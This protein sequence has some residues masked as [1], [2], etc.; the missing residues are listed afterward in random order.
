[1]N[2]TTGRGGKK[3]KNAK[4]KHEE[5]EKNSSRRSSCLPPLHH[6]EKKETEK[7]GNVEAHPSLPRENHS[8]E[9]FVNRDVINV[10][11]TDGA[12]KDADDEGRGEGHPYHY[13]PRENMKKK[14][15]DNEHEQ[16]SMG[17]LTSKVEPAPPSPT[18]TTTITTTSTILTTSPSFPPEGSSAYEEKR[19][20]QEKRKT[21]KNICKE[22]ESLQGQHP[23]QQLHQKEEEDAEGIGSGNPLHFLSPSPPPTTISKTKQ[24]N[25]YGGSSLLVRPGG[26]PP[27]ASAPAPPRFPFSSFSSSPPPPSPRDGEEGGG[28]P[29]SLFHRIISTSEKQESQKSN[30]KNKNTKEKKEKKGSRVHALV[31]QEEVEEERL[32]GGGGPEEKKE[33]KKKGKSKKE[34]E[35]HLDEKGSGGR[36]RGNRGTRRERVPRLGHTQRFSYLSPT[37]S[38]ITSSH[39]M[40]ANFSISG[41]GSGGGGP[42]PPLSVTRS[43]S[44][45]SS[46]S[47]A[48]SFSPPP[49]PPFF[50]KTSPSPRRLPPTT[51]KTTTRMEEDEEEKKKEKKKREEGEQ[52]EGVRRVVP[53]SEVCQDIAHALESLSESLFFY[54][55]L[56]VKK[57]NIE[58]VLRKV[59]TFLLYT[60]YD[61]GVS[62]H[63]IRVLV[64]VTKTVSRGTDILASGMGGGMAILIHFLENIDGLIQQPLVLQEVMQWC[65]LMTPRLPC[66]SF[67]LPP[68]VCAALLD[69]EWH[70]VVPPPPAAPPSSLLCSSSSSSV[71]GG[72]GLGVSPTITPPPTTTGLPP[73]PFSS[74]PSSSFLAF[75]QT[76]P[77][78]SLYP[79]LPFPLPTSMFLS[80][81]SPTTTTTSSQEGD[82]T[83]WPNNGA[84]GVLHATEKKST[85]MC[86]IHR[87]KSTFTH[88]TSSDDENRSNC[89]TG[90]GHITPRKKNNG[91]KHKKKKKM[92]NNLWKIIFGGSGGG[93]GKDS[94]KKKE[95]DHDNEEDSSCST[96]RDRD[97]DEDEETKEEE[98][99]GEGNEDD[100]LNR[101]FSS[102]P[103]SSC[104]PS[105]CLASVLFSSFDEPFDL[106]LWRY[107]SSLAPLPLPPPPITPTTT[108]TTMA[109]S[110]STL[111]ISPSPPSSS[112]VQPS[113]P[114]YSKIITESKQFQDEV[115]R[116]LTGR[117][118]APFV[119]AESNIESSPPAPLSALSS[120]FSSSPPPPS[121]SFS[122]GLLFPPHQKKTKEEKEKETALCGILSWM[123]IR[124]RFAHQLTSFVTHE[125]VLGFLCSF[126]S[127]PLSSSS[128]FDH[129][130]HRIMV[131]AMLDGLTALEGVLQGASFEEVTR[132]YRLYWRGTFLRGLERLMNYFL[133]ASKS[134]T[135]AA[136]LVEQREKKNREKKVKEDEMEEKEE[137]PVVSSS[138]LSYIEWKSVVVPIFYRYLSCLACYIDRMPAEQFEEES[139][140]CPLQRQ[141]RRR[142]GS[143][144]E[145]PHPPP[146]QAGRKEE[147]QEKKK[148]GGVVVKLEGEGEEKKNA[149]DHPSLDCTRRGRE[150]SIPLRLSSPSSL[151]CGPSPH[152]PSSHRGKADGET[153]VDGCRRGWQQPQQQSVNGECGGS[154]N[155]IRNMLP[156]HLLPFSRL[157]ILDDEE[158]EKEEAGGRGGG[159]FQKDEEEEAPTNMMEDEEYYFLWYATLLCTSI[160]YRSSYFISMR[161]GRGGRPG[162][163]VGVGKGGGGVPAELRDTLRTAAYSPLLSFFRAAPSVA[164]PMFCRA[165]V[166]EVVC[167]AI[168]NI[169]GFYGGSG[170][171]EKRRSHVL[172]EENRRYFTVLPPL[173][174]DSSSSSSSSSD[175]GGDDAV[176]DGPS[177]SKKKEQ[178]QQQQRQRRCHNLQ[179]SEERGPDLPS[180]KNRT[181]T[182]TTASSAS[183]FSSS[184][185]FPLFVEP[186]PSSSSLSGAGG[187]EAAAGAAGRAAVVEHLSVMPML[188]LLLAVLPPPPPS[189]ARE[190]SKHVTVPYYPWI[191][192]DQEGNVHGYDTLISQACEHV[193]RQPE[194]DENEEKQ[195]VEMDK[196]ERRM[197]MKMMMMMKSSQHPS[198][199]P[200][201][202]A[203]H[204]VMQKKWAEEKKKKSGNVRLS[205]ARSSSVASSLIGSPH[206]PYRSLQEITPSRTSSASNYYYPASS[207]RL[208]PRLRA[209]SCP[210]Q[211]LAFYKKDL[212]ASHQV[213]MEETEKMLSMKKKME[214]SRSSNTQ[215]SRM[216]GGGIASYYGEELSTAP[217]FSIPVAVRRRSIVS[218][219]IHSSVHGLDYYSPSSSPGLSSC[220]FPSPSSFSSLSSSSSRSSSS[221]SSSSSSRFSSSS[222]SSPSGSAGASISSLPS[223]TLGSN[224]ISHGGISSANSTSKRAITFTARLVSPPAAGSASPPI[225]RSSSSSFSSV[226]SFSTR[227]SFSSGTPFLPPPPTTATTPSSSSSW[228]SPLFPS[229]TRCPTRCLPSA[230]SRSPPA[231]VPLP[232][233]PGG[234]G[235]AAAA[236]SLSF[237]PHKAGPVGGLAPHKRSFFHFHLFQ[238]WV[239]GNRAKKEDKTIKKRKGKHYGRSVCAAAALSPIASAEEGLVSSSTLSSP[240]PFQRLR[241]SKNNEDISSFFFSFLPHPQQRREVGEVEGKAED[242]SKGRSTI[243][244]ASTSVLSSLSSS[245]LPF[246]PNT[247]AD[248][249]SCGGGCCGCTR[250][251][252]QWEFVEL[253]WTSQQMWT[254]IHEEN[255]RV[256]AAP[257]QQV[258]SNAPMLKEGREGEKKHEGRK[259]GRGRGETGNS[260]SSE[261][262]SYRARSNFFFGQKKK[263]VYLVAASSGK[264][265]N[266]SEENDEQKGGGV[267]GKLANKRRKQEEIEEGGTATINTT[268]RMKGR[269]R[270]TMGV[271]ARHG[272]L[273]GREGDDEEKGEYLSPGEERNI[274]L[275]GG[276]ELLLEWRARPRRLPM[277]RYGRG[278]KGRRG[279][280]EMAWEGQ[281][282][283][284][285]DGGAAVPPFSSSLPPALP[286]SSSSSS[287]RITPFLPLSPME[288]RLQQHHLS[289]FSSSPPSSTEVKSR[290]L[291]NTPP[292][293]VSSLASPPPLL[294]SSPFPPSPPPHTPPCVSTEGWSSFLPYPFPLPVGATISPTEEEDQGDGGCL[295]FYRRSVL[296]LS[297]SLSTPSSAAAAERTKEREEEPQDDQGTKKKGGGGGGGEEKMA[298][299]QWHPCCL[300]LPSFSFFFPSFMAYGARHGGLAGGGPGDASGSE[301]GSSGSSSFSLFPF[302]AKFSGAEGPARRCRADDVPPSS[303]SP[304]LSPVAFPLPCWGPDG[305]PLGGCTRRRIQMDMTSGG[306][307]RRYSRDSNNTNRNHPSSSSSI[308]AVPFGNAT[309][310]DG[311]CR[312]DGRGG[313]PSLSLLLELLFLDLNEENRRR[314]MCSCRDR[315]AMEKLKEVLM[316]SEA[317]RRTTGGGKSSSRRKKT[318][319]PTTTAGDEETRGKRG[320]YKHKPHKKKKTKQKVRGR[321]SRSQREQKDGEKPFSSE[322]SP[323]LLSSSSPSLLPTPSPP[324]PPPPGTRTSSSHD[325]SG[326]GTTSTTPATASSS[327][328]PVLLSSPSPSLFLFFPSSAHSFSF[329]TSPILLPALLSSPSSCCRGSGGDDDNEVVIVPPPPPAVLRPLYPSPVT[330]KEDAENTIETNEPHQQEKETERRE[331]EIG[332][333]EQRDQQKVLL[334]QRL[335]SPSSPSPRIAEFQA[336]EGMKEVEMERLNGKKTILMG[337]GLS[338]DSAG[339]AGM[340]KRGEE[341]AED[342]RRRAATVAAAAAAAASF[343]SPRALPPLLHCSDDEEREERRSAAPPRRRSLPPPSSSAVALFP[344][345]PPPPQH[346]R[347]R[348][349]TVMTSSSPPS[350]IRIKEEQY[351]CF[352]SDANSFSSPPLLPLSSCSSSSHANSATSITPPLPP[353]GGEGGGFSSPSEQQPPASVGGEYSSRIHRSSAP[354]ASIRHLLPI[355]SANGYPFSSSTSSSLPSSSLSSSP[356]LCS[357]QHPFPLTSMNASSSPSSFSFSPSL[358]PS[359]SPGARNLTSG[360][361]AAASGGGT[362]GNLG[363]KRRSTAFPVLPPLN[364]GESMQ[365]R[366][367]KNKEEEDEL[368]GEEE[369]EERGGAGVMPLSGKE[370]VQGE[371]GRMRIESTT[372]T[373]SSSSGTGG[374]HHRSTSLTHHPLPLTPLSAPAGAG[375][376]G[377]GGGRRLGRFSFHQR[378]EN[379]AQKGITGTTHYNNNNNNNNIVDRGGIIGPRGYLGDK[380]EPSGREKKAKM[381]GEERSNAAAAPPAPSP[382]LQYR[383]FG[384]K[385]EGKTKKGGGNGGLICGEEKQDGEDGE[386]GEFR[387]GEGR[388]GG[389]GKKKK[390]KLLEK[391]AVN[392]D[393]ISSS[394]ILSYRLAWQR[395]GGAMFALF[396]LV[397]PHVLCTLQYTTD[398]VVARHCAAIILRILALSPFPDMYS[399]SPSSFRGSGVGGVHGGLS[400]W[401]AKEIIS[402]LL[403]HLLQ[404]ALFLL[405]VRVESGEGARGVGGGGS[406]RIISV[407]EPLTP[408]RYL[409]TFGRYRSSLERSHGIFSGMKTFSYTYTGELRLAAL[410][411]IRFAL[412]WEKEMRRL[413]R[414]EFLLFEKQEEEKRKEKCGKNREEKP[415]R[416]ELPS[417]KM[418]ENLRMME[419]KKKTE[420][421]AMKWVGASLPFPFSVAATPAVSSSSSSF[422]FS[423]PSYWTGELFHNLLS[424]IDEVL[425]TMYAQHY[426]LLSLPSSSSSFSSSFFSHMLPSLPPLP[427]SI[428][429]TSSSPNFTSSSSSSPLVSTAA[430]ASLSRSSVLTP[431]TISSGW[432]FMTGGGGGSAA[433]AVG[434][435]SGAEGIGGSSQSSLNA[436]PSTTITGR[437]RSVIRGND[438]PPAPPPPPPPPR[439][440]HR[441]RNNMFMAV[442]YAATPVDPEILLSNG[443]GLL[444]YLPSP[445]CP[446]HQTPLSLLRQFIDVSEGVKYSLIKAKKKIERQERRQE[447]RRQEEHDREREEEERK[448]E[449]ERKSEERS[450][451]GSGAVVGTKM[452]RKE[453]IKGRGFTPGD[454]TGGTIATAANVQTTTKNK[455]RPE[456][457]RK[458][459]IRTGNTRTM[460]RPLGMRGIPMISLSLPSS[461]SSS[462]WIS[463]SFTSMLKQLLLL[464]NGPVNHTSTSFIFSLQSTREERVPFR[465]S[466]SSS[467]FSHLAS[468]ATS[469]KF[470]A[471]QKEMKRGKS[472]ATTTSPTTNPFI[473]IRTMK[474]RIEAAVLSE[475]HRQARTWEIPPPPGL[476]LVLAICALVEVSSCF[477]SSSSS[478]SSPVLFFVSPSL[479]REERKDSQDN[480]KVDEEREEEEDEECF[481]FSSSPSLLHH[482]LHYADHPRTAYY[483]LLFFWKGPLRPS[484]FSFS[485]SR[486]SLLLPEEKQPSSSSSSP[487]SSSSASASSMASALEGLTVVAAALAQVP[488]WV[489]LSLL[490]QE[491]PHLLELAAVSLRCREGRGEPEGRAWV[492]EWERSRGLS[493]FHD[494][495]TSCSSPRDVKHGGGKEERGWSMNPTEEKMSREELLEHLSSLAA[496]LSLEKEEVYFRFALEGLFV[497]LMKALQAELPL[498]PSGGL[499]AS[500]VVGHLFY[501]FDE[502]RRWME[503]GEEGGGDR[504]GEGEEWE[505]G[506]EN[507]LVMHGNPASYYR[508]VGGGGGGGS[509]WRRTEFL[510]MTGGSAT[511]TSP[512]SFGASGTFISPPS[513]PRSH[514]ASNTGGAGAAPTVHNLSFASPVSTS[515]QLGRG[516]P[517][518]RGTTATLRTST[519]LSIRVVPL[520]ERLAQFEKRV[521]R[522]SSLLSTSSPFLLSSSPLRSAFPTPICTTTSTLS[523]GGERQ[524]QGEKDNSTTE[525]GAG[526]AKGKRRKV[527][528]RE[529]ESM[530]EKKKKKEEDVRRRM[531]DN[532]YGPIVLVPG[533]SPTS[534]AAS[535]SFSSSSSSPVYEKGI[536]T[537]HG[538]PLSFRLA[539]QGVLPSFL[540]EVLPNLTLW[541]VALEVTA[542]LNARLKQQRQSSAAA[543]AAVAI[544]PT[545]PSA[546]VSSCSSRSSC[547]GR[548]QR[549]SALSSSSSPLNCHNKTSSN[550]TEI[551]SAKTCRSGRNGDSVPFTQPS[552]SS[553]FLPPSSPSPAPPSLPPPQLKVV[554]P[555]QLLFL[556]FNK[557]VIAPLSTIS[558]VLCSTCTSTSSATSFSDEEEDEEDQ[559]EDEEEGMKKRETGEESDEKRPERLKKR[560]KRRVKQRR[561]IIRRE[562]WTRVRHRIGLKEVFQTTPPDDLVDY[563]VPSSSPV[564]SLF[565]SSSTAV[566]AAG[567]RGGGGRNSSSPS[568]SWCGNN[569]S[570]SMPIMVTTP[571]NPSTSTSIHYWG[572]STPTHPHNTRWGREKIRTTSYVEDHPDT[573]WCRTSITGEDGAGAAAALLLPS[574]DGRGGESTAEADEKESKIRGGGRTSEQAGGESISLSRVEETIVDGLEGRRNEKIVSWIRVQDK[575]ALIKRRKKRGKGEITTTRK[576]KKKEVHKRRRQREE[577]EEEEEAEEDKQDDEMDDDEE[578]ECFPKIRGIRRVV[579]VVEVLILSDPIPDALLYGKFSCGCSLIP[580]RNFNPIATASPPP[581]STITNSSSSRMTS[582]VEEKNGAERGGGGGGAGDA[583]MC[584]T[585]HHHDDE[586]DRDRGGQAP[587]QHS[588]RNNTNNSEGKDK[589]KQK[590]EYPRKKRWRRKGED[591]LGYPP[592][593]PAA[594]AAAGASSLSLSPPLSSSVSFPFHSPSVPSLASCSS[595]GSSFCSF[596]EPSDS[597]LHCCSL[598]HYYQRIVLSTRRWSSVGKTAGPRGTDD[599]FLEKEARKERGRRM[600]PPYS[601]SGGGFL[602][603][604]EA[605]RETRPFSREENKKREEE[606]DNKKNNLGKDKDDVFS[607]SHHHHHYSL[608]LEKDGKRGVLA[609]ISL[610]EALG[611]I[612]RQSNVIGKNI[613]DT[614]SNTTTTTTASGARSAASPS[615]SVVPPSPPSVLSPPFCTVWGGK[616]VGIVGVR[617]EEELEDGRGGRRTRNHN[618]HFYRHYQYLK[619]YRERLEQGPVYRRLCMLVHYHVQQH[620]DLYAIPAL[621]IPLY[622]S[623]ERQ[624]QQVKRK[625][626]QRFQDDEEEEEEE[627]EEVVFCREGSHLAP[628]P[629]PL[630]PSPAQLS[631][632][633]DAAPVD[634]LVLWSFPFLF[635]LEL[636]QEIFFE[637]LDHYRLSDVPSSR[638]TGRNSDVHQTGVKTS[639]GL[640]AGGASAGGVGGGASGAGGG[641]TMRSRGGPAGGAGGGPGSGW[642]SFFSVLYSSPAT[643]TAS[644]PLSAA[645]VAGSEGGGTTAS[646][647][648]EMMPPPPPSDVFP[649][650]STPNSSSHNHHNHPDMPMFEGD[651][652]NIN[653]NRRVIGT[654]GEGGEEGR[655]PGAGGGAGDMNGSRTS[656]TTVTTTNNPHMNN[657]TTDDHSSSFIDPAE[658]TARLRMM[659]T[660]IVHRITCSPSSPPP[661]P[662]LPPPPPSNFTSNEALFPPGALSDAPNEAKEEEEEGEEKEKKEAPAAAL[663]SFESLREDRSTVSLSPRGNPR[664][665]SFCK[666]TTHTTAPT[667]D[668]PLSF[669]GASMTSST[670]S[671][672]SSSFSSSHHPHLPQNG[673]RHHQHHEHHSDHNNDG[674]EDYTPHNHN[675]RMKPE[676]GGTLSLLVSTEGGAPV[677]APV[678][679]ESSSSTA[680]PLLSRD[681]AP[682][683]SSTSIT[684]ATMNPSP[685]TS[686]LT[687][688]PFRHPHHRTS[689][690]ST[691]STCAAAAAPPPSPPPLS[692]SNDFVSLPPVALPWMNHRDWRRHTARITIE[693]SRDPRELLYAG[694]TFLHQY[695][696]C[697]LPLDISYI[698]EVGLGTGPTLEFL[699]S[700]GLA[701]AG[702]N[703]PPPPHHYH[704]T[705]PSYADYSSVNIWR[706]HEVMVRSTTTT[707]TPHSS[708]WDTD[709]AEEKAHTI[710]RRDWRKEREKTNQSTGVREEKEKEEGEEKGKKKKRDGGG[711]ELPFTTFEK[712]VLPLLFPSPYLVSKTLGSC[713]SFGACTSLR[714]SNHHHHHHHSRSRTSNSRNSADKGGD[715]GGGEGEMEKSKLW[716]CYILGL[717]IGRLLSMRRVAPFRFHPLFLKAFLADNESC[718][719]SFFS[720]SPPFPPSPA[721]ALS[722][723]SCSSFGTTSSSSFCAASS[724]NAEV[725]RREYHHHLEGEGGGDETKEAEEGITTANNNSCCG[726]WGGEG[727]RVKDGLLARNPEEAS[728]HMCYLDPALEHSLR[729]LEMLSEEELES[730]ELFFVFTFEEEVVEEDEEV[731]VEVQNEDEVDITQKKETNVHSFSSSSP[732]LSQKSEKTTILLP[733]GTTTHKETENTEIDT[734]NN[735]KTKREARRVRHIRSREEPLLPGGETLR[736]TKQNVSLFTFYLRQRHLDVPLRPMLFYFRQGLHSVIHPAYFRLFSLPELD[737][738]WS[739]PGE[740]R[741]WRSPEALATCVVVSHGYTPKSET[742]LNFLDVVGNWPG[743]YQRLF[744]KYLT[745]SSMMPVMMGREGGGGGSARGGGRR[746][747]RRGRRRDGSTGRRS[748][749][750]SSTSNAS[751]TSSSSTATTPDTTCTAFACALDPPITIARRDLEG[752]FSLPARVGGSGTGKTTT[753]TTT[754]SRRS[755]I[756]GGDPHEER[757]VNTPRS[758]EPPEELDKGEAIRRCV[759]KE[760]DATLPS[761]STC[762]H[763][764]KLPNYSSCAVLEKQLLRAITDGQGSFDLT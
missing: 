433:C 255:K 552:S 335:S 677:V 512:S 104:T 635:H 349:S 743:E 570:S 377:G 391:E 509:G 72:G 559:D 476:R 658:L 17:I 155:H 29:T 208:P 27:P 264:G 719:S 534:G 273:E 456:E 260:N 616:E 444:Y 422:F 357:P 595:A 724:T 679:H 519:M 397:I 467:L 90:G 725:A 306:A 354:R 688:P 47:S 192:E 731:E 287:L 693:V 721:A 750:S 190:E 381:T 714:S 30:N 761:V 607:P 593:I 203:Q 680:P 214:K 60:R 455:N 561:R 86:S 504:E 614:T 703:R 213:M 37:N 309:F 160:L 594:A 605:G 120:S 578:D 241:S 410:D 139:K 718:C 515:A 5:R 676:C 661:S 205:S 501:H 622:R 417:G 305:F 579:H 187:A 132:R 154:S 712:Q 763:Y 239:M 303:P 150:R 147:A 510:P 486:L 348:S 234:G 110:Y 177:F 521:H 764:L 296:P 379:S 626:Q 362:D 441:R 400:F 248:P 229:S 536:I 51:G 292:P 525:E 59:Y 576:K 164:V 383:F 285:G 284:S 529:K 558:E 78:H 128:S 188:E 553:S 215:Q 573:T 601:F 201:K 262:S 749:S 582:R 42:L 50:L 63:A 506:D 337:T 33:G 653:G 107:I 660:A 737:A 453:E 314:L 500:M 705:S 503:E 458:G 339:D 23:Q 591:R 628:P 726:C 373:T 310:R 563:P 586:C 85:T 327:L 71:V 340:I 20:E 158:D 547:S 216:G 624:R 545:S 265:S 751:S 610:A 243:T 75:P 478:S 350:P 28:W 531:K 329:S 442:P 10:L 318:T 600:A 673:K 25:T 156:R 269:G 413:E 224:G 168:G 428:T 370:E 116:A 345:P 663:P 634:M 300:P 252:R 170:K 270:S 606:D 204:T 179:R 632:V 218:G 490:I 499:K 109:S 301:R 432:S 199:S 518:T 523:A 740:D 633:M 657:T 462:F 32:K 723:S 355:N 497:R 378:Q 157:L 364:N 399:S 288:Y 8:E 49:P 435:A 549:R 556:F 546:S 363:Y 169:M 7:E 222:C 604:D 123:V 55:H 276:D 167:I 446:F 57:L 728:L 6:E 324:V 4:Q 315:S 256:M 274:P 182:T 40:S 89:G 603:K 259:W 79:P 537:V 436:A 118:T 395:D 474:E 149:L 219:F 253:L 298:R 612:L 736:V 609:L 746:R 44:F 482:H 278:R 58:K 592:P 144:A 572:N 443:P 9:N 393:P 322:P 527:Q 655:G 249:S 454:G 675:R 463:T 254:A 577:R 416:K 757:L 520:Q 627:E 388:G 289:L 235:G 2:I 111:R 312:G 654:A 539:D 367:K 153:V 280:N 423:Y 698:G 540:L 35:R 220:T 411:F 638:L 320:K 200:K 758:I 238:R 494:S 382:T 694:A 148:K 45:S 319:A 468:A 244:T 585:K 189:M 146:P 336:N 687:L 745:G 741:V 317:K 217:S 580:P 562:G 608:L 113:P 602:P 237:S 257:Q 236:A 54:P 611:I 240:L 631:Q 195:K 101:P 672:S 517:M 683:A 76:Y 722:H 625:E 80:T 575:T 344:P 665:P 689:T 430:A 716:W 323:L 126:S 233:T 263:K 759:Q 548:R 163:M 730:M 555:S 230:A 412:R 656:T 708:S 408:F 419:E 73:L 564:P 186:S 384:S 290:G 127:T 161:S 530:K 583:D 136:R 14:G 437:R 331:E 141:R 48:I 39:S 492:H 744:L 755:E 211:L 194:K 690:I 557:P 106:R 172:E 522:H 385:E 431:T 567:G 277:M 457:K 266:S 668:L 646:P 464:A 484:A 415:I 261:S 692:S 99:E 619:K 121:L 753:A 103:L 409:R 695:A 61:P 117:I 231:A 67:G 584:R 375:S 321:N 293:P 752:V 485:S 571:T 302:F 620:L 581:F 279:E 449:K 376:S 481:P 495:A 11:I 268:R 472:G 667:S 245:L 347:Q 511:V 392:F 365:E 83:P 448:E 407:S 197:L 88:S 533:R 739:G 524:R 704:P 727:W 105:S 175:G 542:F 143:G 342:G 715:G 429:T 372:T 91:K 701:L 209:F 664:T 427:T 346:R 479:H 282:R 226:Q 122:P 489:T 81:T 426:R 307:G 459:T 554:H 473:V 272:S 227:S 15:V 275:F 41:D 543:A 162:E 87:S 250:R 460:P 709:E 247:A 713:P 629:P 502:R 639:V 82:R 477:S 183:S 717:Y 637:L 206:H 356:L 232:H 325:G 386:G 56:F 587:R 70:P 471:M 140:R 308:M 747:R 294:L 691:T 251:S 212:K 246:S 480:G 483:R 541:R 641:T 359:S 421:E 505:S 461:T 465:S 643:A 131:M 720:S 125:K 544:S 560:E 304:P 98:G 166:L 74:S 507:H 242:D 368:E 114:S 569:S 440:R 590:E 92:S 588:H 401:D 451:G 115:L 68:E 295:F 445:T 418:N 669:F 96:E 130:P 684:T 756:H 674:D 396:S 738:L 389:R 528:V 671:S 361:I 152:R 404:T 682:S 420:K 469:M 374:G 26:A 538:Y 729:Q 645:G 617:E 291:G 366:E 311:A 598:P 678:S 618:H 53:F 176:A 535:P 24:N 707:T 685:L 439:D 754:A 710:S 424:S 196:E 402:P 514:S 371:G 334:P 62:I 202:Q 358:S 93:K 3:Q 159:K 568:P 77:P 648:G 733:T 97:E 652:G 228:G 258:I 173:N 316:T 491:H 450:G 734:K 338:G 19:E 151:D 223:C 699:E 640:T 647:R 565:R 271:G 508:G 425:F 129:H 134:T 405:R 636:R 398:P 145:P 387:K 16:N 12:D 452:K 526:E 488:R 124:A 38:S 52:V 475:M 135:S 596:S 613:L 66:S 95:N 180:S 330:R 210:Q 360:T 623:F 225:P 286:S 267:L 760:V 702:R 207:L 102:F 65:K 178:Q 46:S 142:R 496:P 313:A 696:Y 100:A 184:S 34:D 574:D 470:F 351:G 434:T 742:I 1:M 138:L 681:L 649:T 181:T 532:N 18:F 615:S 137:E 666:K 36:S 621:T 697:P 297:F 343:I 711:G 762:F 651:P 198:P 466:S 748:S 112:P 283:G 662:P 642:I 165:R 31:A 22:E 659:N 414:K 700:F 193:Y 390:K 191:W 341:K 516:Q 630:A 185:S 333:E 352:R 670:S 281:S 597:Y 403:P 735:R 438:T 119:V 498:V 493:T 13:H 589:T 69:A 686:S 221:I 566:D 21:K 64:A 353:R 599:L 706:T 299:E 94:E 732:S 326:G 644:S 369:Q 513:F 394:Q 171:G 447:Q 108:T 332:R 328:P 133:P 487:S 551:Q 550:K 380:P 84:G 650:G 406:T 43:C 174:A